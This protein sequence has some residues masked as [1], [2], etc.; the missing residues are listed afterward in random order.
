MTERVLPSIQLIL[1]DNKRLEGFKSL[2]EWFSKNNRGKLTSSHFV[3]DS[4][5]RLQARNQSEETFN[6]LQQQ[7]ASKGFSM[8]CFCLNIIPNNAN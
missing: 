3:I 1:N 2:F 5:I 4:N 6:Y 7:A 8:N